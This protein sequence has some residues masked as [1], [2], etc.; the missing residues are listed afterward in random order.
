MVIDSSEIEQALAT[1][2]GWELRGDRIK[3]VFTFSGFKRAFA[4]MT[5]VALT[6]EAMNHHPEWFNVYGVVKVEL[7]THDAGGITQLDL[8]LAR[9][10][11]DAAR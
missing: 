5:E 8:K 11:N 2:D 4:F 6:A 9:V 3:K 7:T 1:L 10:M